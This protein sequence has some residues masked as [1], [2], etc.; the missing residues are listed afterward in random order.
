MAYP[1]MEQH[2]IPQSN[3]RREK[4]N[5]RFSWRV[6]ALFFIPV[7][8]A[9]LTSFSMYAALEPLVGHYVEFAM[10]LVGDDEI[11]EPETRDFISQLEPVDD[12]V[13]PVEWIE[14]QDHSDPPAEEEQVFIRRSEIEIPQEGDL[15]AR[16][17]ISGTTIDAPV[18]WGDSENELNRGVGTFMGGWL[19]GFGRTVMMAGHRTTD[20]YD[21]RSVEI[22]AI[23]TVVTHY[24]TYTYEVVRTA[25]HHMNDTDSYDFL[26]DEENII[27]YT[28]YPFDF[29]GAARER[30]FVYG[31]PL[32]GT[33]VARYS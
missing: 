13:E 17:T 8:F 12:D 4:R 22:G 19:P 16:I 23:I 1:Q 2:K 10:L 24:E 32:T 28:C 20:F 9:L 18:F 26:R 14:V 3:N 21:M 33:P 5:K 30:F 27:L 6:S 7:I 31:E 11:I 29:V 25:V 15:Y